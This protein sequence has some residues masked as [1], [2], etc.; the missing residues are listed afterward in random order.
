MSEK[1]VDFVKGFLIGGVIGAAL[2]ILYAPKSGEETREDISKKTDEL[3]AKAKEEYEQAAKKL[4]DLAERGKE[5]IQ[6]ARGRFKK[7]IDYGIKAYREK[8]EE[9]T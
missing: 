9:K 8:Q 5:E 4:S 1:I 6:D 3:L 7:A 2:G